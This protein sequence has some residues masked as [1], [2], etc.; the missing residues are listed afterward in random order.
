MASVGGCVVDGVGFGIGGRIC[1][2]EGA[3]EGEDGRE[4]F[5]GRRSNGFLLGITNLESPTLS[6]QGLEAHAWDGPLLCFHTSYGPL[7]A[8]VGRFFA[9]IQVMGR[10]LLSYELV[11]SSVFDRNVSYQQ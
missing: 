1:M 5:E 3:E 11:T 6:V 4:P 10:Y 2:R 7:L 8:F 9:F